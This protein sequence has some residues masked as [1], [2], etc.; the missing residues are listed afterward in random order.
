MGL[1]GSVGC[2][3]S[4]PAPRKLGLRLSDTEH[5]HCCSKLEKTP[6]QPLHICRSF[7]WGDA[8]HPAQCFVLRSQKERGEKQ[9]LQEALG[10]PQPSSL[11]FGGSL[12]KAQTQ[13]T[14]SSHMAN[15]TLYSQ[16]PGPC[17]QGKSHDR[18]SATC[19]VQSIGA[20]G[21]SCSPGTRSPF[22]QGSDQGL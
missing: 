4:C 15:S 1:N 20:Q 21:Q 5:Q 16:R 22:L 17:A 7:V 14:S 8:E 19:V 9:S 6:K 3:S 10:S 13:C 11:Y 18:G 12:P 2:C